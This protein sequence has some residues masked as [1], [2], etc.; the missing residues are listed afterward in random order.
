MPAVTQKQFPRPC[1]PFFLL[2]AWQTHFV[3]SGRQ[4]PGAAAT[5]RK[6]RQ[7]G[8][9]TRQARQAAAGAQ[10]DKAGDRARDLVV[11]DEGE[12][13]WAIVGGVGALGAPRAAAR[14]RPARA[15]PRLRPSRSYRPALSARARRRGAGAAVSYMD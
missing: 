15:L 4:L 12:R 13:F 1:V 8:A 6:V 7:A 10:Q 14:A 5:A 9:T 3:R 2:S 11:A